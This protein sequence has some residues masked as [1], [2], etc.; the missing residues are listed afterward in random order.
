MLS[1]AGVWRAV[2]VRSECRPQQGYTMVLMAEPVSGAVLN[3]IFNPAQALSRPEELIW[4]SAFS[5]PLSMEI[6][7]L[8]PSDPA[9][10]LWTA[11]GHCCLL[12]R[13]D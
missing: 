8:L 4:I 12:S 10:Q 13:S 7:D 1:G 6:L 3:A 11:A 9:L 2:G 5:W